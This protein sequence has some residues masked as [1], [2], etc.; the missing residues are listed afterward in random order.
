MSSVSGSNSHSRNGDSS[1]LV[2]LGSFIRTRRRT[3]ELT[4]EQLAERLGWVQERIS[5]LEHGKYGMPSL[6]SLA[7]LA[8]AV[9]MELGDVLVSV[10][11]HGAREL[12]RPDAD[13][14]PAKSAALLYTLERLIAIDETEPRKVL[15]QASSMIAEV[16]SAEK[17]DAFM[18]DPV[19]ECLVAAG[20][21]DTPMG[22]KQQELG[23]DRIPTNRHSREAEVYESGRSYLTGHGEEDPNMTAGFVEQLGVRSLVLVALNVAGERRGILAGASS[24]AD[25]FSIYDLRFF[26][27]VSR[28]IGLVV[29]RFELIE[30][31]G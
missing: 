16:M 24:R 20:T 5:L 9:E 29:H 3:L 30:A 11:Y 22:R 14:E 31:R 25:Q 27:S 17:V 26:D 23:L 8:T 1:N 19:S 15:C 21:S 7:R 2:A 28:W 6:P 12:S 10:G 18:F 13:G 4:Q